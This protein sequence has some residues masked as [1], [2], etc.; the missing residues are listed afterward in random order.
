MHQ[1]WLVQQSTSK[2]HGVHDSARAFLKHD[3]TPLQRQVSM[4]PASSTYL[5]CQKAEYLALGI[6]KRRSSANHQDL[7]IDMT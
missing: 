7:K 1:H 6:I 2:Q 5:F 4:S 3:G